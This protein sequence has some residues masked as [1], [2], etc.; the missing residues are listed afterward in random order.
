MNDGGGNMKILVAM[1]S[2][3]GSATS[4]EVGEAV[5]KGIEESF[6]EE[7]T[8]P[9]KV[10]PI[11]DGGEGTIEAI[12]YTTPNSIH[13][14]H[15][16]GPLFHQEVTAKYGIY[17]ET[18]VLEVAETSGIM[19]VEK[20]D[21]DPWQATS[22]GLGQ[23]LKKNIEA[24][25]RKFIIGLG[26]SATNDAGIGLLSALGY[27]FLDEKG[28]NLGYLLKD[29]KYLSR[30]DASSVLPELAECSIRI[31]SDVKNPLNGQN[32]AT[33]IFGKQKGVTKE[34]RK[35][36]DRIL[37]KFAFL[38]NEL[39]KTFYQVTPG[40]GAAGGLGFTLLSYF[41]S[42]IV[43]GFEEVATIIDLEKEIEQADIIIT[44][45]GMLDAQSMM[46][47]VPVAIAKMAKKHYKPVIA[48][49][50]GV[51]EDAV[52]CNNEGIDAFF[53][54]IRRIASEQNILDR[55]NTINAVRET[56]QQL[57]RFGQL[58]R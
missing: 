42:E 13:T 39:T 51:S 43:S 16:Q 9:I 7:Q 1:D 33:Y 47:K 28:Q 15:V 40:S 53:P 46:G 23:L 22:Y 5:K 48:I 17:D 56:A 27:D 55:E 4:I 21:L 25:Y 44:G 58:F 12:F 38:T 10:T 8:V 11:A 37:E 31:A 3:K 54:T 45:E 26:G 57:F 24:G 19:L 14:E 41:K 18:V 32:G 20:K 35:E 36:I 6:K 30:I 29:M 52:Q 34:N 2:F 50:G 49:S